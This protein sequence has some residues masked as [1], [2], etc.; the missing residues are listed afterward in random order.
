MG[1]TELDLEE[2]DKIIRAGNFKTAQKKLKKFTAKSVPAR[3]A[4]KASNILVR[5]GLAEQGA[6]ILYPLIHGGTEKPKPEIM[7]EYALALLQS[8]AY[9]EALKILEAIDFKSVPA[10]NF[11][12]SVALFS[13][14]EHVKA[15]PFLESYLKDAQTK[16]YQRIVASANLVHSYILAKDLTSAENLLA[17]VLNHAEKENQALLLANCRE[18]KAQ[19]L[20]EQKN[21]KQALK[22][23]SASKKS[24]ELNSG[25]Y[26][27]MITYWEILCEIALRPEDKTL[28][29]RWQKLRMDSVK[30]EFWSL[31]RQ[32]DFHSAVLE[33]NKD[34][35]LKLYFGTPFKSYRE[36]LIKNFPGKCEIPKSYLWNSAPGVVPEGNMLD[37]A[38]GQGL[39]V[40]N[41]LKKG[42]VIYRILQSL[43]SDFYIPFKLETLF[44]YVFPDEYFN[45]RSSYH[46]TANGINRASTWLENN[47]IPI[48]I[49]FKEGAYRIFFKE[50]FYLRVHL[51]IEESQPYDAVSE[52]KRLLDTRKSL[53]VAEISTKLKIPPRSV[54]RHIKTLLEQKKIIKK[55]RKYFKVY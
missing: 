46:K 41:Q 11:Y 19:L 39:T 44:N 14:F 10:A 7:A 31:V 25:K 3:L 36:K 55:N 16:P 54:H 21:Y 13:K 30:S 33:G 18:L 5:A 8:G 51:Q 32:C 6:R 48:Q 12:Y 17:E 34:L 23:L 53:S 4:S 42:H 37:L 1:I 15:I 2:I 35:F 49:R 26:L 38:S 20:F 9:V 50:P 27:L 28:W 43:A 22:E 45:P 40:K 52:I 24:L 29:Q 47:E